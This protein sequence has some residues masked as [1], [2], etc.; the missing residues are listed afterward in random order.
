MMEPLAGLRMVVTRAEQQA[1]ELAQPLRERGASVILLPV[2]GIA[3]PA[4]AAPLAEAIAEIDRYD[5]IVFTSVNGIR[6]LGKQQCRARV[7]TVG[8]ATREFAERNGWT[9]AITP[10]TYVAEALVEALGTEGLS[11]Q[12]M[13]IPSA[14]VR[15]D[16]VRE[17]LTRR[18]AIVDVV[19]AYRNVIPAEAGEMAREVFRLP[20]P[21]WVTFASSSAVENLVSLVAVER[22][23]RSRIASIGPVTSETVR[24]CGMQAAAEARAHT[25]GGLIDAIVQAVADK[26]A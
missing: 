5:W 16:V 21:D 18:G 9:V 14:A 15:R 13:L 7:A 2:I 20:F 12:R 3:P 23:R 6:A 10:E 25:I 22:L 19:E 24:A 17:E 8:A 26:T 1:E 4:N 11:G